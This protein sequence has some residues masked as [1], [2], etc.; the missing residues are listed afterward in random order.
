MSAWMLWGH[1]FK[2][3][4]IIK[5]FEFPKFAILNASIKH[6]NDSKEYVVY[7]VPTF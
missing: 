4:A 5:K 1:L 2:R 6:I 7:G 3:F